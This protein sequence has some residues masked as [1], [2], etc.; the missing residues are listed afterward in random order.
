M[1]HKILIR[2]AAVLGA[3][4]VI[5]AIAATILWRRDMA[6]SGAS[7]AEYT[8]PD[9]PYYTTQIIDSAIQLSLK[10]RAAQI[11][12]PA[13]YKDDPGA[14]PTTYLRDVHSKSHGC[15]LAK[16][17]V[18]AVQDRFAQGVFAQ[19]HSFDAILRFSSGK[20]GVNSD[21]GRDARGLAIKLLDVSGPKLLSG[22]TNDTAQDFILMNNPTFFIRTLPEYQAFSQALGGA[23]I[24]SYFMPSLWHPSAW[25]VRELYLAAQTEKPRPASLATIRYWSASAYALG[26]NQFVKYSVKPCPLNKPLPPANKRDPDYLRLELAN[27]AAKGGDC[28]DFMVQPQVMGKNMPL[29]DTT[30]NWSE[31]DSP[32]SS[33]A[34]I[35]IPAQ[36]NNTAAMNERC[37]NLEFNP[38]HSLAAHRPVGAMNRVR[39]ALY[40]AMADFRRSKNGVAYQ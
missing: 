7:M 23:G 30:V 39:E 14:K 10:S 36:Q 18:G 22:E 4:V 13:D 9:E 35:E 2:S 1:F 20:P 24:M 17:N 11:A 37:E 38:W 29:E 40:Q 34:R 26:P 6:P 19:P 8:T 5:L 31:R 27:Q 33:V 25:H 16:F 3:L 12:Q 32:F 21:S 15:V 28:F